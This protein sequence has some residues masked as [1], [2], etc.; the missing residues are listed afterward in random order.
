M[1]KLIAIILVIMLIMSP[2]ATLAAGNGQYENGYS[3]GEYY[4]NK[5]Y[6]N[7]YYEN[8]HL[9]YGYEYECE[10]HKCEYCEFGCELCIFKC[11]CEY[12]CECNKQLIMPFGFPIEVTTA[13]QLRDEVAAAN[14][15]GDPTIIHLMNDIHLGATFV[16]IFEDANITIKT[17]P[18]ATETATLWVDG[19]RHFAVS[20]ILTLED[21][22]L[23]RG[24]ATANDMTHTGHGGGVQVFPNGVLNMNAGATI[25]NTL[26]W[27]GPLQ[28]PGFGAV[29]GSTGG[30]AGIRGTLNMHDG[31]VISNNRS[32]GSGGRP[33]HGG[34]VNLSGSARL[35]MFGGEIIDNI[36]VSH[37]G[38]VAVQGS[39]RFYMHGGYV[40][41]NTALASF[42]NDTGGAGCLPDCNCSVCLTGRHQVEAAQGGGVYLAGSN[43]RFTMFNGTISY[44]RVAVD[45]GINPQRAQHGG[46]VVIIH[47]TFTMH[48]GL[49]TRNFAHQNGGGV[50]VWPSGT[51][52]FQGAGFSEGGIFHFHGGTIS[53][54]V[55]ARGG[56]VN[57][58]YRFNMG[59]PSPHSTTIPTITGNRVR[60]P[61]PQGGFGSIGG[62]GAGVRTGGDITAR[63][64][65][66]W[67]FTMYDGIISDNHTYVRY[68]DMALD[69]YVA[70]GTSAVLR[71][72]T[73]GGGVSFAR[74][75]FVI[76]NGQII[77]N[78]AITMGGGINIYGGRSLAFELQDGV[79]IERNTATG[80]TV[81]IG[82]T[83]TIHHGA[84]GGIAI[85]MQTGGGFGNVDFTMTGG[86]IRDNEAR[87][88]AGGP[89]SNHG[90][91]GTGGG[92]HSRVRFTMDGGTIEGNTARWGGGIFAQDVRLHLMGGEID[93]NNAERGGGVYLTASSLMNNINNEAHVSVLDGT[94]I[95]NNTATQTG[96]GVFT[97][98]LFRMESGEINNNIASNGGG[99]RLWEHFN[100]HL[101]FI[102]NGGQ[103]NN[104]NAT[105]AYGGWMVHPSSGGGISA[106]RGTAGFPGRRINVTINDGEINNNT[107]ANGGGIFAWDDDQFDYQTV[108]LTINNGAVNHNTATG[109]GGG[110]YVAHGA[111]FTLN[112]GEINN[113]TA[114]NNGGGVR[115]I[116][117]STRL[118]AYPLAQHIWSTFNMSGGMISD[119]EAGFDGGG[120]CAIGSDF[121]MSGTAQVTNNIS[122]RDGGGVAARA[123]QLPGTWQPAYRYITFFCDN[124]NDWLWGV[125]S[126]APGWVWCYNAN[127]WSVWCDG[128]LEYVQNIIWSIATMHDNSAIESN[129]A[130]QNGGGVFLNNGKLLMHN[131]TVRENEATYG[132]GI[133]ISYVDEQTTGLS[134]VEILNGQI[135][136][137]IAKHDGGGIWVK[138]LPLHRSTQLEIDDTV[139]F[140]DNVA[141]FGSWDYG[142]A[143]GLTDFPNIR[144]LGY[145]AGI[146]SLPGT[147]ALNN[148]DINNRVLDELT[149]LKSANPTIVPVNG[150]VTYTIR[151]LNPNPEALTNHMVSDVLN[152]RLQFVEGSVRL[153][154]AVVSL[155]GYYFDE[156]TRTLRV[157]L[158]NIPAKVGTIYGEVTITFQARVLSRPPAP[159]QI[160]NRTHLWGPPIDANN[161]DDRGYYIGYDDAV[162]TVPDAP[163]NGNVGN[164][165]GGNGNGTVEIP[166]PEVPLVEFSPYHYAYIIGYPDGYVRPERNITRAE[167]ATIFFRLISDDF[168]ISV[169]SQTNP[170]PDVELHQ[171]FNNAISTL[172]N[173]NLLYG[174]P[175]GYFRPDQ[176][177]TRAEFSA[178]I[179]RI[180]GQR[181]AMATATN[182]FLD[183]S[184]HWGEA[185]ISVAYE[186]GWVR[187]YP[188]G[189]FRPD[190]FITRAEVAA[191]VNRALNRLPETP[192]D[193][194]PEMVTWPDNMNINAW[195]YLYMQ[196]ATNSHYHEMKADGIH[197]TWTEFIEPREWWR[198]ERP[199]SDPWIFTGAYIGE[200]IGMIENSF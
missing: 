104:N 179:V 77:D 37:G 168:R 48:G 18:L 192:A 113:N 184:G 200:G 101:Y 63:H 72:G 76:H 124:I 29:V 191:L 11:E 122:G 109:N 150:T 92:I 91:A 152:E 173:A 65:G 71:N 170:F 93:D 28:W 89:S 97:Q 165:N 115:V 176:S 41:G 56:G 36:A 149:I 135:L 103:I 134:L 45:V 102:M 138:A 136:G 190:R 50:F 132:G 69:G 43:P 83:N 13:Q 52:E 199:H 42:H 194:L 180:M 139:I 155:T 4:E 51:P 33:T 111:L 85:G 79:Y 183:V 156:A 128:T 146:N 26:F 9:Q 53:Y 30:A 118:I 40:T 197:E 123:L 95:T 23:T 147:H 17:A 10:E 187:G 108:H 195:Y 32:I 144:W 167:V 59:A 182:S 106:Q 141:L 27:R 174:Y 158:P 47:G 84:G 130:T 163:P 3:G 98:Q 117:G 154:G 151:V 82:A 66:P 62:E 143:L 161:P 189:T 145:L 121:N 133:F 46:G 175:D 196:E 64:T 80:G 86:I 129:T 60:R 44:N 105:L 169:W 186:L 57:N 20:G 99:V 100:W 185:Y 120:V 157:Y 74:G 21:I 142:L 61:G 159:H 166:D 67:I 172:T 38:G 114:T 58:G 49:I 19:H 78:T 87:F 119:N 54:N 162:V 160:P 178:V 177:M 193:L 81:L 5:Y 16:P 90:I 112:D 171:W 137:N 14:L 153:N 94:T 198:L 35:N 75:E 34:G 68:G 96:G 188:D 24:V 25:T 88:V 127:W 22:I 131:G 110:V 55:A 148:Y 116:S 31:A 181:G 1:R 8:G 125:W 2:A 6:E 73:G 107:A 164:G 70:A 126:T 12:E 7:G 140:D 39:S 15:T